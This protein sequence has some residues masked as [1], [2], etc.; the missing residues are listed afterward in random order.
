MSNIVSRKREREGGGEE[1]KRE[2]RWIINK[3][4]SAQGKWGLRVGFNIWGG[5]GVLVGLCCKCDVIGMGMGVGEIW[6]ATRGRSHLGEDPD[7][8]KS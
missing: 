6:K 8:A 5:R 3:K 1:W 2:R 7:P 4:R